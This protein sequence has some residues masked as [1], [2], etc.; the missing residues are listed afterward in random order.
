MSHPRIVPALRYNNAPAA[1]E[2][3]CN[4]FGFQKH[5]VVPM[6]DGRIAHAQLTIDGGMIMLGSTKDDDFGKL[7]KSAKDAGVVTQSCYIIVPDA[8][9]HY[10][11]AVAAGAEILVDIKDED[12]GG[13]GYTCRDPEGVIWNI[14]T[15]DPWTD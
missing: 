10:Q 15:Y 7:Q 14:G 9:A 4:A 5:L 1:I 12:Y 8:D 6:D 11:R 2:W 13:R 3:L